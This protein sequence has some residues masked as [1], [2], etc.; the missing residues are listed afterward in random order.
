MPRPKKWRNVCHLP[1]SREYGPLDKKMENSESIYMTVEEY[2][3]VRLIDLM[4]MTQEECADR[5][6]VSRTT[7][8]DIYSKARRKM[9]DS[10]VG[11]TPLIIDGGRYR[12]CDMY[13]E[14]CCRRGMCRR[15]RGKRTNEIFKDPDD[16]QKS[17]GSK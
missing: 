14:D 7:V 15:N 16:D 5:M 4:G 13:N 9:A 3:S 17:G 2:E 11:G 12:I 10:L 1:D 6:E 8:Q